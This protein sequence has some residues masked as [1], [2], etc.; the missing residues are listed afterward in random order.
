MFLSLKKHW[1]DTHGE[2]GA[3][4]VHF[5]QE[6]LR[7]LRIHSVS[8]DP[9]DLQRFQGEVL[10]LEEALSEETPPEQIQDA[11]KSLPKSIQEHAAR[12]NRFFRIQAAELHN[13][14]SMMAETIK[15]VSA[16]SDT[17]VDCLVKV[18]K[19]IE[20]ASQNEDLKRL[21]SELADVLA[22]VRVESLRQR[23]ETRRTIQTLSKSMAE[24]R[25][26]LAESAGPARI[27]TSL[28]PVTGL[29]GRIAAELAL[30]DAHSESDTAVVVL[31]I[32]RH[33]L[34][35]IRFGHEAGDNVLKFLAG[36][37]KDHLRSTDKLFRWSAGA[38][39]AI[40]Q[41]PLPADALRV[42]VSRFASH[43]LEHTIEHHGRDVLLPI[44]T[45]WILLPVSD[46]SSVEDLIRKID[47]FLHND[48]HSKD[49][50]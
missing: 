10:A 41:R 16:T 29:G 45:S 19:R 42:E 12:T 35:Q 15:A 25:Q 3:A 34:I 33:P 22:S 30:A 5:S 20:S 49:K 13:M 6:M 47:A 18:E 2:L 7:S 17:S 21:K 39:V 23:E 24:S 28:D 1:E 43:K 26:R 11:A 48:I 40:I 37:L 4:L 38:F 44:S 50:F 8:G 32:D 31:P 27:G 46:S 14:I 9:A 36:H